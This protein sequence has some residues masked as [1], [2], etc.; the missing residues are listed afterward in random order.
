MLDH[1]RTHLMPMPVAFDG[2]VEKPARVSSTCLIS[3][4][5]NRYSEPCELHG[6]MVST[7]LYSASVM[8]VADD[9]MVARYD[10]LSNAGETCYDWQH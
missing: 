5:R 7:R 2:Y 9:R 3:V 8:V 4:A 10:R 6:Q 1:E